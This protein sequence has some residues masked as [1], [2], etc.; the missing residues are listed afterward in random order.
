MAH[1]FKLSAFGLRLIKAYEGFRSVE[2]TLVS[3]QQIIGYGHRYTLDEEPVVTKKKAEELLKDDLAPYEELVNSNVYAPLT[4]S[5]FDALVSLAFNIG[6][7]AFLSS[8]V[9]T[10]LNNG[11]PLDAAAGFDEWRKSMINDQVYV[12]DA[13]VRRRTAEK[14]LFLKLGDGVVATPRH[15]LP[16]QSDLDYPRSATPEPVYN[17]QAERGIVP[18][19]PL[20]QDPKNIELVRA[21]DP[22][23]SDDNSVQSS[24]DNNEDEN[25]VFAANLETKDSS[26]F[27][28]DEDSSETLVEY[29]GLRLVD[30]QDGATNTQDAQPS[31][32]ALAAAEVRERLDNLITNP[33]NEQ[34]SEQD[35]PKAYIADTE[36]LPHHE[37]EPTDTHQNARTQADMS[38]FEL[39][40][41]EN[42]TPASSLGY[43]VALV[44][45]ISVM[46]F[47]AWKWFFVPRY[48]LSNLMEFIVPVSMM[49]GAM[50]AL[51]SF[52]Y[53]LKSWIRRSS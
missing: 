5:Q 19:A 45:G 36:V 50:V 37:D 16:V 31:P 13:L 44:L 24:Q 8:H 38:E 22:V 39:T 10:S 11:R 26:L 20:S 51:G 7:Q 34:P 18:Q 48:E 47:S 9:L 43:W 21:K 2:T 15:E 33:P 23:V 53:L 40:D 6:P 17:E 49:I 28:T 52:Y 3:G 1:N 46:A 42:T 4:Q 14:A 41:T 12:V 25:S 32:I 27:R 35:K 30:K 29:N